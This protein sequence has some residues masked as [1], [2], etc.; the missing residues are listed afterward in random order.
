MGKSV[1]PRAQ[2]RGIP[3]RSGP[4]R[5]EGPAPLRKGLEIR[6][7]GARIRRKEWLPRVEG[8]G[9]SAGEPGS[10]LWGATDSGEGPGD[11]TKREEVLPREGRAPQR[12]R[13]GPRREGRPPPRERD[14]RLD[15][16]VVRFSERDEGF[17]ER[18]D[19][20]PVRI[21]GLTGKKAP[22]LRESR[23]IRGHARPIRREDDLGV[24][25]SGRILAYPVVPR[26]ATAW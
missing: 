7:K 2:G 10:R 21:D 4:G 24:G 5:L 25:E 19:R 26:G 22:P 11:S 15:E 14:A 13:R 6:E 3:A 9:P 16:T 23:P 20:F 18:R 12:E 8:R 17:H 1:D